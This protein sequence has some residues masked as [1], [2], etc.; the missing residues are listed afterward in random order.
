MLRGE[1]I[2]ALMGLRFPHFGPNGNFP[3]LFCN[4]YLLRLNRFSL[5]CI[6]FRVMGKNI[7]KFNDRPQ[8]RH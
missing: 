1:T 8:L 5:F 4:G 3:L 6:C 7:P 2:L